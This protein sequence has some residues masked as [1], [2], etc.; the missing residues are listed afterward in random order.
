MNFDAVGK[1]SNGEMYMKFHK[2]FSIVE[3]I[4]LLQRWILVHSF[5][6]YELNE[7][8]VSD[9]K[10]DDN[11][12][13]LAELKRKHPEDFERSRYYLYFH[14]FCSEEDGTVNTSGFDL[15]EKVKKDD[16]QLYRYIWM[17]AM[18]AL[19]QK[20]RRGVVG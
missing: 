1:K 9:F 8:I 5:A 15:L 7:N 20:Q 11:A 12:K 16:E 18:S 3:Q 19:D 4:Q 2:P 14:D 6:Y 13:Q 10:Y 17:D